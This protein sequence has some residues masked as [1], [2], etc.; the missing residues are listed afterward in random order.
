M[1]RWTL[2]CHTCQ[3]ANKILMLSGCL[4]PLSV[5]YRD[6]PETSKRSP[7]N[8]NTSKRFTKYMNGCECFWFTW[9]RILGVLSAVCPKLLEPSSSSTKDFFDSSLKCRWNAHNS[10]NCCFDIINNLKSI[11]FRSIETNL[12]ILHESNLFYCLCDNAQ[13]TNFSLIRDIQ[14]RN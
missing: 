5:S 4:L 14:N 12:P 9:E 6:G 10:G 13:I 3:T 1:F 11:W 2:L 7:I 8:S